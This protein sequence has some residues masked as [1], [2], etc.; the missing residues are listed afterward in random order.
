M[1]TH[2]RAGI[3]LCAPCV[4]EV[5]TAVLLKIRSFLVVMPF[6]IAVTGAAKSYCPLTHRKVGLLDPEDEDSKILRNVGNNLSVVTAQ[7]SRGVNLNHN[8]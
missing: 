2:I 1:K 5:L 4:P 8:I 3:K 7:H 6:A